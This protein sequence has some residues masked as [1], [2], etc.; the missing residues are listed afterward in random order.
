MNK[1][2]LSS[3]NSLN[4]LQWKPP[5]NG[6]KPVS[7]HAGAN[8]ERKHVKVPKWVGKFASPKLIPGGH[9]VWKWS[10]Q[11]QLLETEQKTCGLPSG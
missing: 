10:F 3:A 4:C 1:I 11:R 6:A 8:W 7:H 9:V 2:G 5:C